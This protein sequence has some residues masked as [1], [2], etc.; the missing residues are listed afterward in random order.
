MSE[1]IVG[2]CL[3]V[4][5]LLVMFLSAL[6]VFGVFT[7]RYNPVQLFNFSG[8]SIDTTQMLTGSLSLEASQLLSQGKAK[9]TELI[10]AEML[11]STSNIFAH[12]ILVGFI[13]G[14][15][16]KVSSL[17]VMMLR[18]VVVNLKSKE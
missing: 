1:K 15:G 14:L 4:F 9:P 6:N 8:I 18:P 2:Y 12:M 10:S 5:G 13:V 7:K 3:L 16:Y 17:G 11:N